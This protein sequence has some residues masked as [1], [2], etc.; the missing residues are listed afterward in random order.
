MLDF[1]GSV[2]SHRRSRRSTPAVGV[3]PRVLG[4][5][6]LAAVAL[7]LVV[8]PAHAALG[9]TVIP[10]GGAAR[11]NP[12]GS[13][14]GY[15]IGVSNLA[16]HTAGRKTMYFEMKKSPTEAQTFSPI[17]Y[18]LNF[19]PI[20]AEVYVGVAAMAKQGGNPSTEYSEE[21]KV[22]WAGEPKIDPAPGSISTSAGDET[23]QWK[24]LGGLNEVAYEVKV[25][26]DPAPHSPGSPSKTFFVAR[27]RGTE[28][29]SF[30]PDPELL[31]FAPIEGTVYA[32]VG[33][34]VIPGEIP[35]AFTRSVA[36]TIPPEKVKYVTEIKTIFIHEPVSPPVNASPP[37]V[38][39]SALVG[40]SL[41]AS[42]GAWRGEPTSYA[43]QWQLCSSAGSG[44]HDIS[45]ATGASLPLAGTDVGATLRVV[46][47]ASNAGGS[48]TA[49]SK[50]SAVVG[51][52][53]GA[54]MEWT[55]GLSTSSTW[56]V[57]KALKVVAI[58]PGGVVEVTCR[59]HGCP[60]SS[61]HLRPTTQK[62]RCKGARCLHA[63]VV[64]QL[65]LARLF[66][67]R[68][69]APG[70]TITVRIVE[71]G[72]IGKVYTFTL[73]AHGSPS[74]TKACLTPGSTKPTPC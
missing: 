33:T 22:P 56:T 69:L 38:S 29:Q 71:S 68:H 20:G 66:K 25:W 36:L 62:S 63:K 52:E 37:S 5:A 9:P 6:L 73:R 24:S 74:H 54:S 43:Y 31:G 72:W 51:S 67:A 53:V 59:G 3:F 7:L 13:E 18:F 57:V 10:E 60:I 16:E 23:L 49:V 26:S 21:I 27:D 55:F 14:W 34:I 11:W 32:E 61:T 42:F 30:K 70:I 44:C 2:E 15:K 1:Y 28:L 8:A 41:A 4:V 45:G 39:G 64:T 17:A 46:V 65:D 58:P 35:A 50:P 19:I 47:V 12:V 48:A 40:A